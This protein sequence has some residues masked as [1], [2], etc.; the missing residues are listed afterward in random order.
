M[1][2]NSAG[3]TTWLAKAA[4]AGAVA[5]AALLAVPGGA[6]AA[7]PAPAAHAAGTAQT[8]VV[9]DSTRNCQICPWEG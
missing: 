6:F 3:T 2:N 1:I 5:A 9:P 8:S 7:R 4:V